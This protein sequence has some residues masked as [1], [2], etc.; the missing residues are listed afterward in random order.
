MRR[1]SHSLSLGRIDLRDWGLKKNS[2]W[3]E[4]PMISFGAKEQSQDGDRNTKF[5]K[6]VANR[7]RKFNTIHKIQVDGEF[8]VDAASARNMIV[9]FYENLY[10]EDQPSRFFLDG[11]AFASISPDDAGD[12][13]K[14]FTEDEVSN[15]ICELGNEKV[16]RPDG[17]NIAFFQYCWSIVKGEIM[18][19]FADFHDKGVFEK[20]LNATFITLIPKMA[21]TNDIKSFRPTNRKC[22]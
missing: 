10:H 17:F 12:L 13:V 7:R 3:C 14:D 18:G 11:I 6:Q 4:N 19:F 8:Y 2:L 9:N 22:I 16:P 5:F 15:T 20:S 21:C 1:S